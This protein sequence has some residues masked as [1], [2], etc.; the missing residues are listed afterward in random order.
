MNA[1]VLIRPDGPFDLPLSL[2]AAAS[3][4]PPVALVPRSLR[5]AI[6]VSNHPAIIEICQRSRVPPVIAASASIPIPRRRL[7]ELARWLTACDLDLR[8]FY[9]I[10]AGHPIMGPIAKRLRGLKPLR[11]AS[12]FEM[13]LI[14]ITEQQL[15]LAAAFHIR[16][17]LV[18]RFGTPIEDL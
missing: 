18:E 9:R 12:L 16:T 15:S 2:T 11:P 7:S 1:S 5:L 3:F 14:A 17:R 13:A 6:P 8:A 10:V 4:L